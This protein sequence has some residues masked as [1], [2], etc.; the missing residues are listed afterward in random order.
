MNSRPFT[1]YAAGEAAAPPTLRILL[2]AGSKVNRILP[3]SASA[4]WNFP[5]P[6][7]KNTRSPATVTPDFAGRGTSILHAVLPVLVSVAPKTPKGGEPGTRF[8]KGEPRGSVP[9]VRVLVP[10]W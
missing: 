2:W 9:R 1:T 6:S 4:A 3:L 5:F 10:E 8:T 7:P